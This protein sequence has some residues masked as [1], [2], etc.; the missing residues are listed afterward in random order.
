MNAADPHRRLALSALTLGG[1]SLL[2]A[3]AY[4]ID[5]AT[6]AP[7]DRKLVVVMLREMERVRVG[8]PVKLAVQLGLKRRIA[9]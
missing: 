6:G 5:A 1:A 7:S 8:V 2:A 4:S 9:E 3:P